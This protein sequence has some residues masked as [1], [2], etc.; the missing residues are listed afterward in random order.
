MFCAN[1]ILS[2][3]FKK[4]NFLIELIKGGGDKMIG[5]DRPVGRLVEIL[6]FEI[7]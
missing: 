5:C 4:A 6:I 2:G 7:L 1:A 3:A